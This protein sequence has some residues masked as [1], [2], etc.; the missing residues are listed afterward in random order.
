[1]R[2]LNVDIGTGTQDILLFDSSKLI[3][4]CVQMIMPS[5][6]TIVATKIHQAT[7]HRHPIL[8]TGVNMGG[9]T[10]QMGTHAAYQGW[11]GSLCHR[12]SCA[13]F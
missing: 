5:P 8:L 4:N 12:G 9:W 2:I 1:M 11:I 3:E 13:D 7:V 10:E 6:T